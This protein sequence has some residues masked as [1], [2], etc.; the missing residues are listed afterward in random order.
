M[1]AARIVNRSFREDGKQTTGGTPAASYS[2]HSV[3]STVSAIRSSRSASPERAVGRAPVDP[4]SALPLAPPVV[5]LP[6]WRRAANQVF[7]N[8]TEPDD[9]LPTLIRKGGITIMAMVGFPVFGISGLFAYLG[10][11]RLTP[12]STYSSELHL[13]AIF[14]FYV[15]AVAFPCYAYLRATRK[16]PT[17]LANCLFASSQCL[18]I[19]CAAVTRYYPAPST[20]VTVAQVAVACSSLS[21]GVLVVAISCIG[22]VY[23]GTSLV[24]PEWFAIAVHNAT[25]IEQ[26][27]FS[28]IVFLGFAITVAQSVASR[29]FADNMLQATRRAQEL[30]REVSASLADYD[31]AGVRASLAKYADSDAADKQ[32]LDSFTTLCNNLERY[33]PHLPNYVL[34]DFQRESDVASD[35]SSVL[36]RQPSNVKSPG[37]G[38]NVRDS[39][40]AL[41]SARLDDEEADNEAVGANAGGTSTARSS[42]HEAILLTTTA[43]ASTMSRVSVAQVLLAPVG[44]SAIAT[45]DLVVQVSHLATETAA[46][47]HSFIG[48]Q[49]TVTWNA[50]QRVDHPET[51]AVRFVAQLKE[52]VQNEGEFR[53]LNAAVAT[54]RGRSQFAGDATARLFNLSLAWRRV[55]GEL[56][57]LASRYDGSIWVDWA[58]REPTQ[59]EYR[60]LGLNVVPESA[61]PTVPSDALRRVAFLFIERR[62]TSQALDAT[63]WMY[64]LQGQ[65]THPDAAALDAVLA[66]H[67]DGDAVAANR[68]FDRV[69]QAAASSANLKA[70]A[71]A[72]SGSARN[73]ILDHPAVR[74]FN[75]LLLSRCGEREPRAP[76]SPTSTTTP[77]A[78]DDDDTRPGFVATTEAPSRSVPLSNTAL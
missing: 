45:N 71:A 33:R 37:D 32:L 78:A 40:S 54:G 46:S 65:A 51:K 4:S 35:R 68:H 24:W 29:V 43:A 63:E 76:A 75:T 60:F 58:T 38:N 11:T 64:A 61:Y 77:T 72:S 53:F 2:S 30:S 47:L 48:D 36:Q 44:D 1:S 9:D 22:F 69:R 39:E 31:V 21:G 20:F 73:P 28:Q 57:T 16:A 8:L 27:L 12:Q 3:R 56:A 50:T 13:A 42:T 17:W 74:D 18:V 25:P 62:G 19:L 14:L 49:L 23:A 15:V 52:S 41:R 7:F 5:P 70:D 26:F 59:Y 10:V 34:H 55:V 67:R 6:L 66:L